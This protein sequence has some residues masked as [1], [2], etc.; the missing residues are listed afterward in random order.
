MIEPP[1]VKPVS[2]TYDE[3]PMLVPPFTDQFGTREDKILASELL[4]LTK[5][6]RVLL[7]QLSLYIAMSRSQEFGAACNATDAKEG[8]AIILGSLLRSMVVSTAAL[9]DEDPRTSNLPKIIRTALSSERS[10]FLDK[11]HT[12]Y[13]VTPAADASRSLLVNYGR[14]LRRGSLRDAILA[15][16]GV[17]NTFVAH[18]DMQPN[19][20]NRKALIRDL[21][22]VISAASVVIGEANVYVLGRR[23]DTGELRKI[24]RREAN[25]FVETLKRGFN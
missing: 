4:R 15:L 5:E 18:F 7:S 8:R 25:G 23:I 16:I 2:V 21:D 12:H 14:K 24:L 6:L 3:I 22:H 13:S 20:R 10:G 19:P 1:V 9:F 17:R 11:F